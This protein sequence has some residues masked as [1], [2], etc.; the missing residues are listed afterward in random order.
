MFPQSGQYLKNIMKSSGYE[1]IESILKLR[2]Q[3]E[4]NKMFDFIKSVSD[5]IE[6]KE[7]MFGVFKS[8]PNKVTL[9]P[10]LEVRIS[11]IFYLGDLLRKQLAPPPCCMKSVKFSLLQVSVNYHC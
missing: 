6:D 11:F 1:T 9:I 7:E 2:H 10:G 8:N 3:E 4:L 5:I